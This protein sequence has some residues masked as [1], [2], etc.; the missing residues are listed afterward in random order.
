MPQ[1]CAIMGKMV[2]YIIKHPP[3]YKQKNSLLK[4]GFSQVI[5]GITA[6]CI[7]ANKSNGSKVVFGGEI[8][9]VNTVLNTCFRVLYGEFPWCLLKNTVSVLINTE[10]SYKCKNNLNQVTLRMCHH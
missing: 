2:D 3:S 8:G 4:D 7:Y 5:R 1:A 9:S 10:S 6:N